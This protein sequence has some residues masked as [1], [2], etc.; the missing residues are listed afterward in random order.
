MGPQAVVGGE[1]KALDSLRVVF[2]LPSAFGMVT[3]RGRDIT[4]AW[5]LISLEKFLLRGLQLAQ[6]VFPVLRDGMQ[7]SFL[8]CFIPFLLEDRRCI[9]RCPFLLCGTVTQ[10]H[11]Y[12]QPFSGTVFHHVLPQDNGHSSLCQLRNFHML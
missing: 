10:S 7:Q 5:A 3:K 11:V 9:L 2:L 1:E 8:F 12:I 4:G 6:V